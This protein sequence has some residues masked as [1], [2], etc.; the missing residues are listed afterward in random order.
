MGY[1]AQSNKKINSIVVLNII[2]TFLYQ[3]INFLL[4][5]ILTRALGTYDFGIVS[6]YSTWANFLFP[7]ISLSTSVV[8]PHIK[9]YISE[10]LQSR[11]VSSVAGL[12]TASFLGV[13]CVV[14]LF[15]MPLSSALGFE[16]VVVVML[17]LQ[18]F[19]MSLVRF[20][21]TYYTQYQKTLFQI[22]LTILISILTFAGTLVLLQ[23]ITQPENKYLCR[24]I[25]F[26]VPYFIV[27]VLALILLYVKGKKLVSLE[28]WKFAL[29]LCLPMIF[30]QVSHI[31]LSQS[32]KVMIQYLL[33]DGVS[34]AG[35]FGFA[36][37][38]ASIGSV[39][40]T[41][42]NN[43]WT[44][45]YYSM[46]QKEKYEEILTRSKNYMFL[47]TACFCAFY[48][49]IP[50]FAKIMGGKDFWAG[51]DTIPVI[52]L[53]NYFVFLYSFS[54]NYKSIKRKVISISLGTM[55]AAVCN[56]ILNY[57]LIP[58]MGNMG[59][60]LT[61]LFS[62]I[63]LFLFHHFSVG[64]GASDYLYG[65]KFYIWGIVSVALCTALFY[66][67]EG[68][69]IV[70]WVIALVVGVFLLRKIIVQKTLF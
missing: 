31:I 24:I 41:A 62:Y 27:G 16:P 11:Y 34:Q 5:P 38:I 26:A 61:S 25:G 63:L 46:L 7:V 66:L 60:A 8:I 4:T 68:F 14:L 50:E 29:P 3:G 36:Y 42:F 56:L 10:E 20:M 65:F 15:L 28:V 33:P 17:L 21:V 45:F 37:T 30:H 39:L 44:P 48:L 53:G 9:M 47:F 19:G 1:E 57:L 40:W 6:L 59:A 12:S 69:W 22:G 70:R 58:V 52:Y 49:V 55:G 35:I 51:I 13:S 2:G 67:L 32:D 18:C 43:A 23:F 64:K 54:V